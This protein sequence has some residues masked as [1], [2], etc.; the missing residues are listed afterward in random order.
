MVGVDDSKVNQIIFEET[1]KLLDADVIIGVNGKDGLNK[2]KASAQNGRIPNIIITDINMPEMNGVEL[3][4]NIKMDEKLKYIPVL[5]LSTETD[6]SISSAVKEYG[7]AGWMKKPL[8]PEEIVKVVKR[9]F[10][11]N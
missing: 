9:F 3:I 5:V 7:A 11:V 2:I 10:K 1:A 6:A 4:R 8:A